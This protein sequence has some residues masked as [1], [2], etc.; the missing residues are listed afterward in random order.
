MKAKLPGER[1]EKR[2]MTTGKFDELSWRLGKVATESVADC[3]NLLTTKATLRM[4][5]N[6]AGSLHVGV[7]DR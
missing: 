4:V 3:Q 1:L 6:H 2:G 5:V 7:D